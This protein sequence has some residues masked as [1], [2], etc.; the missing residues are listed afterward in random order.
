MDLNSSG[1]RRIKEINRNALFSIGTDAHRTEQMDN[2]WI[3]IKL[4]RRGM[5][6]ERI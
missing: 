2:A 3:G 1:I 6:E 5:L 4:A